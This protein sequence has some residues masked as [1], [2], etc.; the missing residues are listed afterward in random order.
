M[1][2]LIDKKGYPEEYIKHFELDSPTSGTIR[3]HEIKGGDGETSWELP[4]IQTPP[5]V[6][7]STKAADILRVMFEKSK[8]RA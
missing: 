8:D 7:K 4:P 3:C 6:G 1:K 2:F 5:D